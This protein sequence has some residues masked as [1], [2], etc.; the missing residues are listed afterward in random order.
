MLL[1]IPWK[2]FNDRFLFLDRRE[3]QEMLEMPMMLEILEMLEKEILD[4]VRLV[5]SPRPYSR[6]VRKAIKDITSLRMSKAFDHPLELLELPDFAGDKRDHQ[7]ATS[8]V[9][10]YE[11]YHKLHPYKVGQYPALWSSQY[12]VEKA[13]VWYNNKGR[14]WDD[15]NWRETAHALW[16]DLAQK[17]DNSNLEE[18]CQTFDLLYEELYEDIPFYQAQRKF[19]N[20]LKPM[21][22]KDVESIWRK[23]KKMSII[24]L[25]EI[26]STM[27]PLNEESLRRSRQ[28]QNSNNNNSGGGGSNKSR[29][30]NGGNNN[31]LSEST[32][33]AM[34]P[35]D[36]D[37]IRLTRVERLTGSKYERWLRFD[38]D[39]SRHPVEAFADSGATNY[40]LAKR[41][42]DLLG[43]ELQQS[44]GRVR[45]EGGV[46]VFKNNQRY[47]M[48]G[49]SHTCRL[50]YLET[51]PTEY[52]T[53]NLRGFERL[54]R[55]GAIPHLFVVRAEPEPAKAPEL[56]PIE[57]TMQVQRQKAF[58]DTVK[59]AKL[60]EAAWNAKVKADAFVPGDMV[61]IRTK[62]PRKFEVDWYGPYKVV[63]AE[64]LNSYVV[65]EPG[66]SPNK[67]LISGDRIKMAHI[68]GDLTKGWRMPR[69]RGRPKKVPIEQPPPGEKRKRGRP[70][71]IRPVEDPDA[72]YIPD[73]KPADREDLEEDDDEMV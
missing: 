33:N 64:I 7:K 31:G 49:A 65:K 9:T 72:D 60:N 34:Q 22:R 35:C 48:Q 21:T 63:K 10:R 51:I 56:A 43:L 68:E 73:F 54:V 15:L 5:R 61:L 29:G 12:L 25:Q 24:Q 62:K 41:I 16:S 32:L 71:R 69:G 70:R 28:H 58:K 59:K 40:F 38:L 13:A 57:K 36:D 52:N 45:L 20:G 30:G 2:K 55:K 4:L 50:Q 23:D 1:K 3:M 39:L 18:Y 8:W 44:T 6:L 17:G 53:V 66:K 46:Q 42:I 27:E 67:F 14:R 11:K 26:A 37:D 47:K 19:I